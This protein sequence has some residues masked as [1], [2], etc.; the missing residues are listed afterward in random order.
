[1]SDIFRE[2][3]EDLRRHRAQELWRRYG[4]YAVAGALAL[5][6]AVAGVTWWNAAQR[7]A[8]ETAAR[9]FVE[10]GDVAETGDAVAAA[11]AYAAI[12]AQ[13]GGGY[14]AVAGMRAAGLLAE[15]GDVDAAVAAYDAIAAG[16]GDVILRE[17][18][19]L[20]AALLLADTASPD[21]LKIRLTPLARE[22][23][24]WRF[25]AL[26]LLGFVALRDND[27]TAAA[28]Y[29]QTLADADGAPPFARDRARNMLRGLQLE[30]PAARQLPAPQGAGES[31]RV[32]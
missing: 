12:A 19:G 1:L 27:R 22:D 11:E 10:A 2:V 16:N 9:A 31:D 4:A 14:G 15:A 30:R 18:A 29:Y 5:V 8:S 20:K 21:E 24:P 28:G 25:A 26:E 6:A 13:A 17:L 3:D 32:E 23:S 7:S